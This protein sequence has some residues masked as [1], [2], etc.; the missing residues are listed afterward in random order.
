M[1][2]YDVARAYEVLEDFI[3]TLSTW[4]LRLLKPTLW[5]AGDKRDT[6]EAL[7]A[8]FV[9]LAHVMAPFLPFLAELVHE[10]LGGEESIHLA[11]WPPARADRRDDA[12]VAE[13]RQLRALVRAAR[14]VR[15]NAGIKHRQPL[16]RALVAGVPAAT[17]ARHRDLLASEL[18]VKQVDASDAALARELVLDYAQLG[19]RLRG[20][21]KVVAAA[22]RAGDYELQP[23]GSVRIAD[24]LLAPTEVTWRERGEPVTLDLAIDDALAREGL[25]RELN[26]VV[27][28]LRKQAR[29]PYDARIRLGIA[30]GPAALEACL[31][32][33]GA[34]LCEQAN[35]TALDRSAAG[36]V[37]A[38][39][40]VDGST[41]A[42]ALAHPG[43][44]PP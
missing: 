23:D 6:Y 32:E 22:A 36:D 43:M 37:H 13:M 41:V 2:A 19:A 5:G 42:I 11:D 18:N 40:D 28:D 25:A 21:V 27:Q 24:E 9:Q 29:L 20:K 12:L 1:A 15:E 8:A 34:W 33:H 30:A 44:V 3:T 35:A 38:T 4:Y 26:R 16:R 31:A 14:R 39:L 10:A 7:H 17:L